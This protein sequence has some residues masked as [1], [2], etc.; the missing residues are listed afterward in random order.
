MSSLRI[1]SISIP[2]EDDGHYL[3]MANVHRCDGA[4]HVK[5]DIRFKKTRERHSYTYVWKEDAVRTLT[6]R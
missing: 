3:G 2:I 5:V 1:E 6:V 4:S